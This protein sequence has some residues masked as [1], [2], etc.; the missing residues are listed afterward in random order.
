VTRFVVD[1]GTLLRIAAGEIAV[2]A[3]HNLEGS[4]APREDLE[5][6][7]ALGRVS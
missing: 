6:L 3:E 1:C 5:T 7:A 2:G 4:Y